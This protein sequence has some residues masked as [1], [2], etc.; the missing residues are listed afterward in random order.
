MQIFQNYVSI[1][2][3]LEKPTSSFVC[4]NMLNINFNQ[5]N[6]IEGGG[7]NDYD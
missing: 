6:L 4:H 3:V 7:S 2:G 5:N 1:T